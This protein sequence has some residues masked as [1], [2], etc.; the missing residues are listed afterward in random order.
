MQEKAF[1]ILGVGIGPFNLGLAC[2]ST[3]LPL[4]TIFFDNTLKFEWHPGL[5]IEDSTLQ[6]PFLADLVTLADPTSPFSF[7]NY[8]KKNNRIYLSMAI[9]I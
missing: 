3:P 2:L 8:L 7:L 6:V 9:S 1:D 4:K 5:L